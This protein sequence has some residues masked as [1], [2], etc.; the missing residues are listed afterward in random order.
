MSWKYAANFHENYSLHRLQ[1]L[2]R[3]KSV[4]TLQFKVTR[5]TPF[6]T[7]KKK[8]IVVGDSITKFLHTDELSTSERSVTVMKHPG[9]STE[10]IRPALILLQRKSQILSCYTWEQMI[11]QKVLIPW[12]IPGSVWKLFLNWL[13]LKIS[14]ISRQVSPV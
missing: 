5:K 1:K 8:V 10:D 2:Q 6:N 11:W 12:K 4:E 7:N 14:K 9:C 13:T 3:E